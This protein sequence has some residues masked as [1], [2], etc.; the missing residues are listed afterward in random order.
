[1]LS[2]KMTGLFVII[3]VGFL[4]TSFTGNGLLQGTE[5]WKAP[6]AAD[7]IKS[8]IKF[9][10]DTEKKGEELYLLYCVA[11]H[12][13]TGSGDGPAGAQLPI[14]PANFHQERVTKQTD[15]AI[16]WKLTNGRGPMLPF[17]EILKE[18]ERW[19]VVSYLRQL[20]KQKE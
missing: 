7:T 5:P 9:S 14:K 3:I 18:E 15:G 17:K 8:Q 2:K 12:G 13:E 6:A 1:M 19:Q 16:F 10:A 11:C 20:S 4:L